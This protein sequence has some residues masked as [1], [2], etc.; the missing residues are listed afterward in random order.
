MSSYTRLLTEPKSFLLT[1]KYYDVNPRPKQ[2]TM[3]AKLLANLTESEQEHY[4]SSKL[5]TEVVAAHYDFF[6]TVIE[7]KKAYFTGP[8]TNTSIVVYNNAEPVLVLYSFSKD[9]TLTYFND[10][11]TIFSIDYEN[12]DDEIVAHT[13]LI[14]K[15]K[16][17][18][19]TENFTSII[20]NENTFLLSSLFGKI[21]DTN[22][23][24]EI[25]LN[26]SISKE[27]IKSNIRKSYKSLVNWGERNFSTLLM[28]SENADYETFLTF[29]HFHR[30][31]AGKITRNDESWDLQY[32]AIAKNEA[33]LI[34][35]YY[36]N[37]LVS[38]TFVGHGKKTAYY[39]VGVYN[40]ELMAEDLGLAHYNLM[41]A[42]YHAKSIG[43]QEFCFGYLSQKN[44]DDKESKIFHFKSGF[45]KLM[46]T[47]NSFTANF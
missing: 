44:T 43:L 38:S 45:S 36:N 24:F 9:N 17:F 13:T 39:S 18:A 16:D 4:K 1:T 37:E 41:C 27:A 14:T 22:K 19:Y 30:R 12:S 40:R 7:Y 33:Y 5:Y 15:L 47:K 35:A 25:Y 26:L 23:V 46:R 2:T 3:K 29:K 20:F 32:E 6:D 34:L 10:P 21:T 8:Y 28:T 11:V 31:V 42:I